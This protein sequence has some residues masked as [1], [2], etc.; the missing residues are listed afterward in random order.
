[1]EVAS[2]S[3]TWGAGDRGVGLFGEAVMIGSRGSCPRW[4]TAALMVA[5]F[6]SGSGGWRRQG[7]WRLAAGQFGSTVKHRLPSMVLFHV[8]F[9]FSNS[10]QRRACPPVSDYICN[11]RHDILR[12][13]TGMSRFFI[14][15]RLRLAFSCSAHSGK[16]FI[17][18]LSQRIGRWYFLQLWFRKYLGSI[19]ITI[20]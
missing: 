7:L 14:E 16:N 9:V 3:V 12:R 17:G 1:M 19:L 18:F 8:F 10:N 20:L 2:G 11:L 15:A 13:A 4:V 5:G 6:H